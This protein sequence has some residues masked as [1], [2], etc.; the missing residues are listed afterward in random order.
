MIRAG[1]KRAGWGAH[2]ENSAFDLYVRALKNMII[3]VAHYW[4]ISVSS[5]YNWRYRSGR[6]DGLRPFR[7]DPLP[8]LK[9]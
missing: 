1:I 2:K 4:T 7:K 9:A 8:P 6:K 3:C 5:D